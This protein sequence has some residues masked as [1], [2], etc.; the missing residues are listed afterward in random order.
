M[1]DITMIW[2]LNTMC[3]LAGHYWADLTLRA[4]NNPRSDTP[5]FCFLGTGAI[6]QL[7]PEFAQEK[8]GHDVQKRIFYIALQL[9]ENPVQVQRISAQIKFE[10]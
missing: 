2:D 9:R 3:N 1:Q 7:R 6:S 10:I 8:T 5:V 4:H